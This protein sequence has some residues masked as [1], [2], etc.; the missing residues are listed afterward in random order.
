MIDSAASARS[1]LTP[2]SAPSSPPPEILANSEE[3]K[4]SSG[5]MAKWQCQKW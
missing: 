1:F 3:K 2:F 4:T 5:Q